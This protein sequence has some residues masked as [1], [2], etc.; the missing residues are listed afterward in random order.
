MQIARRRDPGQLPRG[1]WGGWRNSGLR[2]CG[3]RIH[4]RLLGNPRLDSWLAITFNRRERQNAQWICVL[5]VLCG[6]FRPQSPIPN[7]QSA[8]RNS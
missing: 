7:P 5:G 8:I 6:F 3:R 2:G 4:C 1:A